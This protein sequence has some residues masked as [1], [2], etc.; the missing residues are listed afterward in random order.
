MKKSRFGEEQVIRVPLGGASDEVLPV[1]DAT[2]GIEESIFS[3]WKSKH[4]GWNISDI[5]RS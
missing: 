2:C 1:P 3:E 4:D 5:C